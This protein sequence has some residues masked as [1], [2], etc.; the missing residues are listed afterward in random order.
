[1]WDEMLTD[2]KMLSLNNSQWGIWT[3]LLCLANQQTVRGVIS[4]EEISFV[5][6][7]EKI[8]H[9]S[10]KNLTTTL[11]KFQELGLVEMD[12]QE[13]FI[14]I[15]NWNERQFPSDDVTER[16]LKFKQ[17]K[18]S[19]KRPEQNR[20]EKK[21][22]PKDVSSSSM[23]FLDNRG[24]DFEEEVT[25]EALPLSQSPDT[26]GKREAFKEKH[27]G[28]DD[29]TPQSVMQEAV[30]LAQKYSCNDL[31]DTVKDSM[32]EDGIEPKIVI[33]ALSRA[34]VFY[35]PREHTSLIKHFQESIEIIRK[36][37][38]S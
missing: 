18:R 22:P 4:F 26:E 32:F 17:R 13:G 34:E 20:E 29:S 1:M 3:K 16:T 24:G 28:T 23:S 35:E 33:E 25:R 7:L 9:T 14:T 10:R 27:T 19:R 8:L 31:I 15:T 38:T 2:P 12:I 11:K 37:V 30:N 5:R 36:R 21:H 6:V